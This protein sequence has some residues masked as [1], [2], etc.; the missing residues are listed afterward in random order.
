MSIDFSVGT[1]IA[2]SQL[3]FQITETLN[4]VD[5]AKSDYAEL[6]R[7]LESL[8]QALKHVDHLQGPT[9]DSNECAALMCRYPLKDFLNKVRK[10]DKSLGADSI[11]GSISIGGKFHW[12]SVKT[13]EIADSKTISA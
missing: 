13:D 12:G 9:A 10:F 3:I 2:V 4:D 11:A 6:L 8:D 7:E 5:G 1:F